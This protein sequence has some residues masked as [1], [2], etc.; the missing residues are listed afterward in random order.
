MPLSLVFGQPE[1]WP[2]KVI[3]LAVNVTQFPTPCGERC[4]KLGEAIRD[5]VEDLTRRISTCRSGAPAA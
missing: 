4:W 1:E 3:P 5:A 2:C